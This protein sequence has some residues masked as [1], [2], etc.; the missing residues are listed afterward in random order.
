[1]GC[2]LFSHEVTSCVDNTVHVVRLMLHDAKF[3]RR[4]LVLALAT[5]F[6]T[7][8][9]ASHSSPETYTF[10]RENIA[11]LRQ[12]LDPN[13]RDLKCSDRKNRE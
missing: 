11:E 10:E 3:L 5:S 1:M 7:V 2:F 9:A 6:S 13:V 4:A 12:L 8:F